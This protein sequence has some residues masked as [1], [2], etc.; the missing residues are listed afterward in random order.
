VSLRLWFLDRFLRAVVRPMLRRTTDPVRA[1]ADFD[2]FARMF[3]HAAPGRA[4]RLAVP[5]GGEAPA[6][7][8][9]IPPGAEGVRSVLLYFH[10]GGF[11]AG[12]P[13]THRAVI[14]ELAS[15]AGVPVC[16]PDY[17]LAPE[18]P[19]PAAVDDAEAAWRALRAEGRRPGEIAIG[20]DSAG[21][22]IALLL[23]AR[24]CAEG[25]QPAGAV[26][27]SPWA[28]LSGSGESWAMNAPRDAVFPQGRL[29]DLIALVVPGRDPTDPAVS[30]LFADYPGC[31]PVLFF[32]SDSEIL[33]DDSLGLAGRLRAAG[34]D[35]R[36][37]LR[38]ALPHAWPIFAPWLPEAREAVARAG[39]F[40]RDVLPGQPG[41]PTVSR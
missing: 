12:S 3:L 10:G 26:L 2:R 40:L 8:W 9:R 32:V 16:A 22:G 31:P 36:V 25:T 34:T 38:A 21:G 7:V 35:V 11:I 15:A 41:A 30:A 5:A 18:H 14:S 1:R 20:G 27:F 33:R 39:A 28:D 24:L 17:R 6:A 13:D 4:R 29:S 19:L 37:E 23:L